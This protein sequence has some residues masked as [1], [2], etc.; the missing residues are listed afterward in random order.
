MA[1]ISPAFDSEHSL[2]TDRKR[3]EKIADIMYAKIHKTLF[4]GNPGRRRWTTASQS[5]NAAGI[6]QTLEGTGV[7]AE[8][9]LSEALTGLLQYPRERLEGTWE[10][11]AVTIARN[12]AI[13]ALR[14]S[15]KG[16]SGTEHR[17]Q[18]HL[19]SGDLEREGPDGGAEPALFELLPSNWGDPE[20]EYF[21]LQNVLKLR[22]LAR[23]ALNDRD[24]EIFFA[25]H[26]DGY[27]RRKVGER[28]GLTS[29]RIGQIYN[30][31]LDTLEARPDYPFDP[32][33]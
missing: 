19:V 18:L 6:E 23:E 3:L 21:V 29:Q 28:L 11:L 2:L 14:D 26:F 33:P 9:V 27:S 15:K 22:D 1:S 16:L 12:K 8:D 30:A 4:S 25:I 10:G 31:A 24:Q 17:P 7:S 5:D 20:V 13:G 32:R